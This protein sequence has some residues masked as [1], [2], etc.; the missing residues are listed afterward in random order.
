MKFI[1]E[2]T[3]TVLDVVEADDPQSALKALHAKHRGI[4]VTSLYPVPKP[5]KDIDLKKIK[6]EAEII[7]QKSLPLEDMTDDQLFI[8]LAWSFW[9]DGLDVFEEIVVIA[10]GKNPLYNTREKCIHT[11]IT[12]FGYKETL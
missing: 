2:G 8:F 4:K 10:K 11:L 9:K 6:A 7:N 5:N 12:V 3:I 1:Y